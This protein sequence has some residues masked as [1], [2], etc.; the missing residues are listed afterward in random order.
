MSQPES[1]SERRSTA[2][3]A[4]S[5]PFTLDFEGYDVSGET[6]NLS[7]SG[8]LCRLNKEIPLITKVK[9][10]LV[11]P[12]R[13]EGSEIPPIKMTGVVVRNEQDE[14]GFKTAIFFIDIARNHQKRLELFV[15]NRLEDAS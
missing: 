7:S 15:K 8:L 13:L 1:S 5:F 3:I 12:S 2:R 14:V 10:A 9:M 4:A 6:I 11:L